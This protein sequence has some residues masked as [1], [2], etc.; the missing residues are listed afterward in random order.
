M[1]LSLH[2]ADIDQAEEIVNDIK[3]QIGTITKVPYA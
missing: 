2:P 3:S 1:D